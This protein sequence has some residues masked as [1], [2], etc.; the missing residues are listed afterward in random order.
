MHPGLFSTVECRV[1]SLSRTSSNTTPEAPVLHGVLKEMQNAGCLAAVMEVSSHALA[2]ERTRGIRFDVAL[3]TNLTRDHLDFHE[4][5][6]AYEAAKAMLFENLDA[7]AHAIVNGDD[8][9]SDRLISGCPAPVTRYGFGD[10]CDVR[11]Q[12][13]ESDWRGSK[14]D[15][16][17]PMGPV[18]LSFAL[19]G[20]FNLMNAAGAAATALSLGIDAAT[21]IE[22]V[23]NVAVPGRVEAVDR[24]QPFGVLVD[25]AH[26]P[27]ALRNVLQTARTLTGGK[28]I[29]VF[30]AGGDRDPGKRPEMGRVS[31]ELSDLSVVTS[32]N[33][34]TED[35]DRIL[36]Q[37][38]EGMGEL[39]AS[40]RFVVADRRQAIEAALGKAEPGDLVVIAGKGHETYQ[41]VDGVRYPFDDRLVAAELLKSSSRQSAVDGPSNPSHS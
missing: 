17:T 12:S 5:P 26:T 16:V 34:R 24:G 2:L 41:E 32:D 27:D 15:L 20:R 1:G 33:P 6:E 25:Y 36:E 31:A 9:A 29:C 30:G 8:P 37:I 11:I 4:T 38:L 3:F 7:S 22:A 28:L 23:R 19:R 14:M 10:G 21:V 13:G 40:S 39:E 18:S 35:P